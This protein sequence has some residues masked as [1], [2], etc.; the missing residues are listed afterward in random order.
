MVHLLGP[1][2]PLERVPGGVAE[3]RAAG[4]QVQ[5]LRPGVRTQAHRHTSSAVYHVFRGSGYSVIDGQRLD[6]EAGDF[7]ALPIW[8]WHQHGNDGD[9]PAIL[10]SITDLPTLEA[11]PVQMRQLLQN[12]I[13]NALKFHRQG[14]PPVVE[15]SAS[16]MYWSDTRSTCAD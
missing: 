4:V 5:V 12:L 1:D 6:W 11:D 10:F 3:R 2:L 7:L 14:V 9:E 8:A 13:G 16:R 15:V